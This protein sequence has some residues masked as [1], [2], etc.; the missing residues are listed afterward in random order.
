M[1]RGP[2]EITSSK[3]I[4]KNPWI[5]V[6]EDEVIRPNGEKGMFGVVDYLSGAAIVALTDKNEIFLVKEYA[7]AIDDYTISLP[8]G[9][10]DEGESP[11]EAAK[12]ELMEEAGVSAP[13]WTDLGLIHPFTMIIKGPQYLFLAK[14]ATVT[15][16]HEDECELLTIPFTEAYQMVMD[17]KITHAGSCLAILKAREFLHQ[18]S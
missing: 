13:E 8:S 2:Y 15:S 18:Q 14:G 1:K 17:N 9:A 3:Q 5:T 7:Y 11:L 16:G 4:Y 12:R 6:R 10:V